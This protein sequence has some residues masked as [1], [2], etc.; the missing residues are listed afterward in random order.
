MSYESIKSYMGCDHPSFRQSVI[1]GA[2]SGSIAATMTVPFHVVKT[3]Q[4]IE[5]GKPAKRQHRSTAIVFRAIYSQYGVRG[6]YT[7]LTPRLIKVAPACAIM[8]SSF[9]YG[10]VFFNRY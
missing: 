4:Q 3:H 7:G 5:F 10:K 8:I 9:E 1:G 2:I 6:L